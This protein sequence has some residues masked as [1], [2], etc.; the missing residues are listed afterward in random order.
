MTSTSR[1]SI[2]A[3]GIALATTPAALS[4]LAAS[5]GAG[6]PPARGGR[7]EPQDD[8]TGLEVVATLDQRPG[9]IALTPDG[10]LLVRHHPFPYGDPSKHRVVEVLPDGR[11]RPW[12]NG[13]LRRRS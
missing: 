5:P 7:A 2:L 1:R 13:S 3:G 6:L 9:G 12:W 8:A 4:R 11:T 10:R